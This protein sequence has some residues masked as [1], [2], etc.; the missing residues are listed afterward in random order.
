M[1]W[2]KIYR[3][4]IYYIYIII[5]IYY[6]IQFFAVWLTADKNVRSFFAHSAPVLQAESAP[7]SFLPRHV[8]EDGQGRE[9]KH[10]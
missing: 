5:Y 6:I 2:Y 8:S 7:G 10:V 3:L 4:Y 9:G 1:Y